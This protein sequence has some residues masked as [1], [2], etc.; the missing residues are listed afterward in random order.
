VRLSLPLSVILP[1]KKQARLFPL[2]LNIY[3]NTH[4]IVLNQAKKLYKEKVEQAWN[5]ET[6]TQCLLPLSEINIKPPFIFVYTVFPANNRAFD[7][8]NILPIVQKFTDDALIELG[9]IKDDNHKIVSAINYRFGKVDKEKP[10]VEL[11]IS[12]WR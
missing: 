1:R 12:E 3:R 10:R 9:I 8:A 5:E 7:L 4:Y 11:E 2:N 6:Y